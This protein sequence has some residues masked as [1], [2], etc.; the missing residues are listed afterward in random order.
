MAKDEKRVSPK[1]SIQRLRFA[2]TAMAMLTLFA[3]IVGC[4][5]YTL[6]YTAQ[7]RLI[8]EAVP[9]LVNIERLSKVAIGF[10]LSFKELE[11]ITTYHRLNIVLARYRMQGDLLQKAIDD[12]ETGDLD[13]EIIR[14]L[15]DVLR[16]LE[17]HKVLKGEALAKNIEAKKNF[18]ALRQ[19]IDTEAQRLQDQLSPVALDTSLEIIDYVQGSKSLDGTIAE[20]D[21]LALAIHEN[22]LLSDIGVASERLAQIVNRDIV[23]DPTSPNPA[24]LE[25]LKSSFRRLAQL[26]LKLEDEGK[27][28]AITAPLQRLDS[29]LQNAGGLADKYQSL[30]S[31]NVLLE[32]LNQQ[33]T[34]LLTQMT[35]LVDRIVDAAHTRFDSDAETAQARSFLAVL[36]LSIFSTLAFAATVWI[37][38]HLINQDI[39]QRLDRLATSTI[40]LANGDLDV[41]IDQ[42][43]HDELADMARATETFRQNALELRRADA[44]LADRLDEVEHANAAFSSANAALDKVNADLAE[45]ELRY[46][47]AIKGTSVGI[48][49]YDP[50]KKTFFWSDRYREIIGLG[51]GH[52]QPQFD[53]FQDLLHPEDRDWVTSRFHGHLEGGAAYD[54]EYRARH[55]HGH[56]IWIHARGQ[57]VWDEEGKPKR[58]VGSIDDITERKRATIDLANYAKEL[59]RSNQ[60]L[61]DF[62][63][64]ASHDLREP[65][66][67][68]FNHANFLLEDYQDKLEE[69]GEQRLQRLIKLSKRMEQLIADLLY[70]SRLGRGSQAMETLD[71]NKLVADIEANL[72][73]T[74]RAQNA[75][76]EIQGNLPSVTGNPAHILT[77]LQNLISNGA[78][79]ND[80]AEKVINIGTQPVDEAG[81]PSRCTLFVR[82]NGI[83]IDERFQ[84]DI[85]RI[86]K[87]LNNEKA[88]GEG[89][90]AGLTFAKKIVE[91]HGGNI[92]LD[93]A[94]GEGTTFFFTLQR[95]PLIAAFNPNK[96]GTMPD[97]VEPAQT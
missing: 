13:P 66:R 4:V 43:G 2:F 9:L 48:W 39:S 59:E 28:R 73:E 14:D 74:L 86:F 33:G 97:E 16:A 80:A 29:R 78:K 42:N 20:Q 92:W 53:A 44:K 6:S 87:R 91:N 25:A 67:A 24:S 40:A 69:D 60:E 63:Y 64:I 50:K 34:V 58:M 26:I 77:L 7:K 88:Y 3:L 57:A 5:T 46:E 62:A 81:E 45:S 19:Q 8:D 90:G 10:S 47:L 82:D 21:S 51:N 22:Q 75:R 65:L 94:L 18:L 72:A 31:A 61:D 23:A 96:S 36:A 27:R 12:L 79:Y 83:G 70:F 17:E 76:I 32:D 85:F 56:Y 30:H 35:G 84:T 68:I 37:G 54:V 89:T 71:L 93:S 38:K 49:D 95:S 1:S 55:S 41:E 15:K 52:D 11:T